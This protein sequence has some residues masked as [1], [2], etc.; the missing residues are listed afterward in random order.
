MNSFTIIDRYTRWPQTVPARDVKASFIARAFF[1]HWISVFGT[2]LKIT[3][4]QGRKFEAELMIHL[5][6]LVGTH[7]VPRRHTIRR[8]IVWSNECIE[9]SSWP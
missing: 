6:H 4:D 3:V 8:Q 5:G 1:D 7:Y 2:L 9:H